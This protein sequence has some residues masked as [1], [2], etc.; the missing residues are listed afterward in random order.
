MNSLSI[1]NHLKQFQ[2]IL[3][4]FLSKVLPEICVPGSDWW[5]LLVRSIPRLKGSQF[6]RIQAGT[7]KDLGKLDLVSLCGILKYHWQTICEK[8]KIDDLQRIGALKCDTLINLRNTLSHQGSDTSLGPEDSL[9]AL[10]SIKKLSQLIG[11]NNEFIIHLDNDIKAITR[12]IGGVETTT[13]PTNAPQS[14]AQSVLG[15]ED[16][17][18]AP[19]KDNGIPLGVLA[20][21]GDISEE[22]EAALSLTTFIGIDFGTSTTIASRVFLDPQKKNHRRPI[23]LSKN[24]LVLS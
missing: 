8:E 22:L 21:E 1:E 5:T 12:M 2:L 3:H 16:R 13:V 11:T 6:R 20:G 4:D 19:R 14:E 7:L 15:L 17:P 9:A 10:L 23:A 18:I 24:G